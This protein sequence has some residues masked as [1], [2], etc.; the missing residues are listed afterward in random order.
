MKNVI[1]L[2]VLLIFCNQ[3]S[4]LTYFGP[5]ASILKQN[6]F[7]VNI[8]HSESEANIELSG[9]GLSDTLNNVELN[10][11]YTRIYYAPVDDLTIFLDLGY[12]HIE[13]DEF[14]SSDFAYGVGLQGTLKKEGDVTWGGIFQAHW[15]GLEDDW[16]FAGYSGKHE[17][18][19]Y[20]IQV[21]LGPTY[22]LNNISIYGGPF[23]HFIGGDW[24]IT[25]QGSNETLSFSIEQESEFGGYI[26]IDGMLNDKLNWFAEYQITNDADAL[27]FGLRINF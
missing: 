12:A 26:G 10:T 23:F 13:A 17:I 5:P 4:A 11:T 7:A 15:Y 9:Y 27:C 18:D 8:S 1:I 2:S 25:A 3:A 24:D 14:K 20:E 21:A 19:A 16:T 6:E 22:T